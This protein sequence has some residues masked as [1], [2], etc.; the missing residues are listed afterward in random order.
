MA[1]DFLGLVNDVAE[2]RFNEVPLTSA[3][4]TTAGGFYTAA[5]NGVNASLRT[6]NHMGFNWPW[7]H[8]TYS[9]TLVDGQSRYDYQADTKSVDYDTFRIR[10]D[11]AL[12]NNAQPLKYIDYDEYIAK[13]GGEEYET[14][15]NKTLPRYVF[16]QQKLGYGV[17]PVPDKAYTLDYEYFANQ[18][19]LAAATDVPTMPIQF[20]TLIVDGASYYGYIF[21]SDY[22][23]ADRAMKKFT[24][25]INDLKTIYITR[26]DHIWDTRVGNDRRTTDRFIEVS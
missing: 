15:V 12:G 5:K 4:F 2:S 1:Y 25:D 17:W 20:R 24:T 23:A 8:T 26:K 13:F 3:N 19:E 7:N 6:I 22:E 14:N 18:P 9:E 16:Q 10:P 21:R 11:D